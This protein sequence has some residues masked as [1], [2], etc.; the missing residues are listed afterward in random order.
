MVRRTYRVNR[1]DISAAPLSFNE[2]AIEQSGRAASSRSELDKG[3]R[4]FGLVVKDPVICC[5]CGREHL[6]KLG[7]RIRPMSAE[8]VDQGDFLARNIREIFEQPGN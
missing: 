8:L 1:Y 5:N 7:R 6:L 3:L 4:I 2:V